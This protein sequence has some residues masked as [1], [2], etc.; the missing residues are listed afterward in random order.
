MDS[1]L[2]KFCPESLDGS[3]FVTCFVDMASLGAPI[4]FSYAFLFQELLSFT[5]IGLPHF[6]CT[7]NSFAVVLIDCST[8]TSNFIGILAAGM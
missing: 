7:F 3:I 4:S 1:F 5:P 2:G 8:G 6:R